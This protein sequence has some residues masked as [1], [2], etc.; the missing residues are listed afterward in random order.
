MT[1]RDILLAL[2]PPLFWGAGFT[3]AKPA[4]M[5]FPPLFMMLLVYGAIAVFLAFTA[6]SR[7]KTSWSSLVA[8]AA[9][10]V[11]I[12]GALIF[13]GLKGTPASVATLVI[14]I[15]VPFTVLLGWLI[16]NEQFSLRKLAG[17][18]IAMAGVAAVVGL[19]QETP[20]L[21]PIAAIIAGAL[22]WALG[23]VLAARLG[24]DGGI[25]QLKGNAIAGVPQLALATALVESGQIEAVQT[26]TMM[27]WLALGFVGLFGFYFAYVAWFALLRRCRID[28]VAPFTL[29]MPATGLVT[30]WLVLGEAISPAQIAGGLV[31][32]AGL[33]IVVGVRLPRL[34][35][36]AADR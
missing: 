8:I 20:P 29:L 27:D 21:L 12:Q 11:T 13:W 3:I 35:L 6:R 22:I 16:G 30:A 28:E 33:A 19:P 31:I 5:H 34:A 1:R 36:R 17:T 24:K 18:I 26:A 7:I 25:L 9:F 10:T 4:V 14:Q 2:V 32:V 15:Q 23:Q